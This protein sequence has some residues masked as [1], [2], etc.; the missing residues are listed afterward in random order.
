MKI[1]NFSEIRAF[2]TRYPYQI[3]SFRSGTRDKT[4]DF[5]CRSTFTKENDNISRSNNPY[6]TMECIS[7]V[8]E[9]SFRSCRDQCL[10]DLLRDESALPYTREEDGSS[11][12]E[13][14]L[15]E[16]VDLSVVEVCEEE[17]EELLLFVEQKLELGDGEEILR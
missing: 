7:R 11:A 14:E 12:M 17:V 1:A 9:R 13:A 6:I 2:E 8:E 16:C 4:K 15:C 3:R 10:R 5:F